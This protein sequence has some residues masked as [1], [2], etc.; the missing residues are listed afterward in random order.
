MKRILFILIFGTCLSLASSAQRFEGGVI[1]GLNASQVDGDFTSGYHKPGIV[2]GGYVL[3]NFSRTL[4][5]GMELKFNQKGSR[6][7]P[8]PKIPD[9]PSKYIM[10]LNYA[11]MPFY[12]G[13]RTSE[14][15]SL[16][17]GISAGYL[18][19]GTEY[20]NY[21][22]FQTA[23]Q[24]AFNEIDV[25]G[26]LGFR[27]QVNDRLFVDLRGAYSLIPIREQPGD[28]SIYWLDSQFSNVLSTTILY[29][30]DF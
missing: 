3:N 26:L 22:K 5:A 19:S 27:F 25:Q 29:R 8:D 16:I 15:I 21:G 30:L 13:I 2:A 12:L 14:R 24:H 20:D 1:A 18:I 11:D 7:N 23:D 6:R 4:F 10:R 28:I 17:A 9:D